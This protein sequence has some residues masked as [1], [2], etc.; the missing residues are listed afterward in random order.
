MSGNRDLASKAGARWQM[1]S[2]EERAPFEAQAEADK[3]R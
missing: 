1:M 3:L 2:E